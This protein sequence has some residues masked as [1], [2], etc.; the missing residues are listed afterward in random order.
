MI[1]HPNPMI[2]HRTGYWADKHFDTVIVKPISINTSKNPVR[3]VVF[4]KSARDT[5]LT[6]SR[7]ITEEQAVVEAQRIANRLFKTR[8]KAKK[9]GSKASRQKDRHDRLL[10]ERDKMVTT[11]NMAIEDGLQGK[12]D[13]AKDYAQQVITFLRQTVLH[14]G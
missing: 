8:S 1:F 11:F 2:R 3:W 13:T 6:Q 12:H 5:L 14:D 9:K 7:H 4:R 10:V